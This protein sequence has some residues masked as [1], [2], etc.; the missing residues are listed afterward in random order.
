MINYI[1]VPYMVI[2]NKVGSDNFK[3]LLKNELDGRIDLDHLREVYKKDPLEFIKLS[4]ELSFRGCAFKLSSPNN[5]LQNLHFEEGGKYIFVKENKFRYKT[6][7]FD[8]YKL[9]D[10]VSKYKIN[11]DS[12]FNFVLVE[13]FKIFNNYI[14]IGELK[15]DLI[16]SGFSLKSAVEIEA[17]KFDEVEVSEKNNEIVLGKSIDTESDSEHNKCLDKNNLNSCYKDIEELLIEDY[18]REN[19]FNSFRE[20]SK[21]INITNVSEIDEEIIESYARWPSVGT[22]KIS[23]V[24]ERL[25]S[26]KNGSYTV[27]LVRQGED[28]INFGNIE[29]V[30]IEKIFCQSQHRAFILF[31]KDEGVHNLGNMNGELLDRFSKSRGVGIKKVETV[32]EILDKYITI[33]KEN[34]EYDFD[35]PIFMEDKWNGILGNVKVSDIA[36]ILDLPWEL[37]EE[38]TIGYIQGKTLQELSLTETTI[39]KQ[40]IAVVKKVNA[41]KNIKEILT[42]SRAALK[43]NEVKCINLR[44]GNGYTLEQAGNELGL[45]R[46]RVRQILAK[47]IIKIN[48]NSKALDIGIAMELTFYG[49]NFCL[50]EEFYELVGED[51][52]LIA[53][54]INTEGLFNICKSLDIIYFEDIEQ[55]N[56]NIAKVISSLPDVFKFYDKL[57]EI[58]EML[59]E[60]GILHIDIENIERL[61][62]FNDYKQYGE[63]F[64]KFKLSYVDTF[65]IIFR[66]YLEEPMYLDENSYEKLVKLCK[67]HFDLILDNG[68]RATDARI[69]DAENIVLVNRKTFLHIDKLSIEESTINRIR[70]LIDLE[71]V[72]K[73][74]VSAQFILEKNFDELSAIG[75]E[76]KYILYTIASYYLSHLYK[77]GKGNTLDISNSL[78]ELKQSRE[79][80]V[81]ELVHQNNGKISKAE[82]LTITEWPQIKLEDTLCKS[83]ELI[84]VA[85]YVSTAE[86]LGLNND[87]KKIIHDVILR[88]INKNGFVVS[89]SLYNDLVII[90]EIYDFFDRNSITKGDHIGPIAKYLVPELRGN[91]YFFS[92]KGSKFKNFNDVILERFPEICTKDEI[93]DILEC[94]GFKGKTLTAFINDMISSGNYIRI[95]SDEYVSSSKLNIEDDV[96]EVLIRFIEE[97]FGDKEYL[98]LNTLIGFKRKLPSIDYSWDIYLIESILTKHGYRKVE[99]TFFDTRTERLILVR[100]SSPIM[101][102]DELVYYILKNEYKGIM[103]EVKIFDF[104]CE[105][106]VIFNYEKRSQKSIPFDLYKS[107]KF[108]IDEFGRVELL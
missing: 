84:K 102:F 46:E 105:I 103:H 92:L 96:I 11:D 19:T 74:T 62:E 90:P 86:Y 65:E 37:G 56:L 78:E 54:A 25:E 108:S 4:Q 82:I 29:E 42:E 30:P 7:N 87:L 67:I 43:E 44:Y 66:D 14:N 81:L 27:T 48:N 36:E 10:L 60:F 16:L 79:E 83:K 98:S 101:K 38:W 57:D 77:M 13:G 35:K 63:Y 55:L 88:E 5:L 24:R 104:L 33:D 28:K 51:N 75:V 40:L 8:K 17:I 93:K 31:C 73:S 41:Q 71:L 72:E 85:H 52:F 61:L 21:A 68:L 47:A 1:E 3:Q 97:K 15:E 69:R 45:T 100:E 59:S 94:F 64:S 99:R 32:R 91:T 34:L 26:I 6:F 18:F 20:Y 53:K 2:K 89:T 49:K 76:N 106:G 12:F 58:I 22:K 107:D 23:N 9:G 70:E 50:T 95:S 39:Y 80:K